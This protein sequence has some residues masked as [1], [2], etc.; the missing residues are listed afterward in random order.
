MPKHEPLV[1]H[2]FV[3]PFGKLA[4][5]KRTRIP[6]WCY[7]VANLD[8]ALFSSDARGSDRRR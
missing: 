5:L 8:C 6:T 7:V 1:S 2:E 4:N 3:R